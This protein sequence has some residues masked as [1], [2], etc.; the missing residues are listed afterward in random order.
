MKVNS[1][2]NTHNTNMTFGA[3]YAENSAGHLKKLYNKTKDFSNLEKSIK[4]L[5]AN[6][7]NHALEILDAKYFRGTEENRKIDWRET[8]RSMWKYKILNRENGSTVWVSTP[9]NDNHLEQIT[10]TLSKYSDD[11]FWQNKNKTID[12]FNELVLP[13]MK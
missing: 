13:V 8:T 7:P 9:E 12:L 1:N 10:R 11:Y 4:Q 6:R 5:K 3:Y 2:S